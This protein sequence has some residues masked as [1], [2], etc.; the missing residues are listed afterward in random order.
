MGGPPVDESASSS[1]CS[2]RCGS[3]SSSDGTAPEK[4]ARCSGEQ[5][6]GSGGA[7]WESASDREAG[8]GL[9]AERSER[10]CDTSGTWLFC[11]A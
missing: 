3:S 7:E 11:A 5:P 6:G 10:K 1:A 8:E 2:S 4:H 9:A